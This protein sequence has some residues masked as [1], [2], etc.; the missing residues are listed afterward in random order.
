MSR[1]HAAAVAVLTAVSALSLA[2]GTWIHIKAIVAQR[3]LERAWSQTLEG[4][5]SVKPWPWADTE[6]VGRLQVPAHGVDLVVL[7]GA[8]GRTLAFAPGW[9]AG[10]VAPGESGTAVVAGH[11]DTHFAFLERIARGDVVRLTAPDAGERRYEVVSVRIVHESD[12][13][14]L[15]PTESSMLTL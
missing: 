15:E 10:S 6:P 11:R 8:T 5:E 9:L 2:Q 3:L 1:P 14:A 4:H 13:S 7:A 12:T